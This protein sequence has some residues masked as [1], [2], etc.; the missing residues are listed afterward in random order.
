ML[1]SAKFSAKTTTFERN[2]TLFGSAN[3]AKSLAEPLGGYAGA[4][5]ANLFSPKIVLSKIPLMLELQ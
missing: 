5:F 1:F 2:W 3:L 4:K